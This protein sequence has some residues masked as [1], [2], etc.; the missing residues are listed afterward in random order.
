MPN[1]DQQRAGVGRDGVA[2][3]LELVTGVSRGLAD[4]GLDVSRVLD[5][6]AERA[7]AAFAHGCTITMVSD[8]GD[9]VDVVAARDQSEEAERAAIAIAASG[10]RLRVTGGVVG[11]VVR[12]GEPVLLRAIDQ[13]RLLE[14]MN[15]AYREHAIRFPLR[16]LILVPIRGRAAVLG[17]LG[18]VRRGGEAFDDADLDLALDLASRAGVALENARLY[19][20]ASAARLRAEAALAR[21]ESAVRARDHVLAV[22]SHDLRTPLSTIA[23]G[24]TLLGKEESASVKRYAQL[25][26]RA[27]T[28]MERLIGDLLDI[29]QID[30]GALK[31]TRRPH[32]LR[33]LLEQSADLLRP[34]LATKRQEL[35]VRSDEARVDVDRER[36]NQVMA[37]LVGNASKFSAVGRTIRIEATAGDAVEI[38]VVDEGPGIPEDA[39]ATIF[40]RFVQS[41]DGPQRRQGVGLGLAIAKGILEAHGGSVELER[42]SAAG[43]TFL[44]V[45]PRAPR[46]AEAPGAAALASFA[47]LD[48]AAAARVL[49]RMHDETAWQPAEGI[50]GVDLLPFPP[51]G[52]FERAVARLVRIRAGM[53]YPHHTHESPEHILMLSGRL[54]DDDGVELWTGD[55]VEKATGTSHAS[56][57]L[58]AGCIL[59]A[60]TDL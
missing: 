11:D 7:V 3:R 10:T 28:R 46:A 60:R 39:A 57:A 54:R 58:D 42:T 18:V 8:D 20:E 45:L 5:T 22:V 37:N 47:G 9:Y 12:T 34:T 26:Q 19:E 30:A 17:T 52:V 41:T 40:D 32:D 50:E 44:F 59:V 43:T 1:S 24:A 29:A 21:A 33:T 55:A 4:A 36:F 56:T 31:V 6:I 23:M 49:A 38:R 51:G 14:T 2:S 35:V 27:A 15:P 25:M 13:E 16:S 48:V 53:K